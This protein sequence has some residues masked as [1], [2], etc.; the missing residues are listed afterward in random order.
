[1]ASL[2]GKPVCLVFGEDE[3]AV[4]TRAREIYQAWCQ[5]LGGMDH[6]ILDGRAGNSG[7]V[8]KSL[9]RLREALQTLPF[10]GGGKAIWWQNC[11]FL[12][13]D[14]TSASETVTSSLAE[15]GTELSRF[16][17]KGVRLLVSAGKVDKRRS[18]YKT[19]DKI[20]VVE[21][22]ASWAEDD[23]W[24]GRAE[25]AALMALQERGQ[26]I[27]ADA[28]AAL[29][30]AV[31][32]HPRQL[33]SEVE[34][35]SLYAGAR[36]RIEESDVEAV[37]TQNKQ[38][39]AFALGEA[40]G[41]RDLARVLRCLDEEMWEMQFDKDKSEFGLLAGLIGKVRAMIGVSELLRLKWL[42]PEQDWRRY[43]AQLQRIPVDKLPQEK[44]FNPAALHPFVLHKTV[45]H[46]RH[47]S[48]AELVRAMSLLLS[49]N[50]RL[51][52]SSLDA[53]LVLQQTLVDILSGGSGGASQP[54]RRA[55]QR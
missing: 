30:T 8:L 24:A 5:E 16:D 41:D 23:Q 32:P 6:E 2:P 37:V 52:S 40:F 4:Q 26:S 48:A 31:G 53:R 50:R 28:L 19:L 39:R 10:F 46:C 35:V 45:A 3:F 36:K 47:F 43:T 20:G 11:S 42:R 13:D 18:F 14:R 51:I 34:K 38:S 17:W 29:V 21:P 33:A 27:D 54:L 44:R 25:S 9:G 49:C 55:A 15:L 1:M 12:G 22:F 7:D